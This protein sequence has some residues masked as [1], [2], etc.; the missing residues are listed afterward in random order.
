[1]LYTEHSLVPIDFYFCLVSDMCGLTVRDKLF[2]MT[3]RLSK[4]NERQIFDSLKNEGLSLP[5]KIE[6]SMLW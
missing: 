6:N 5:V 3:I 2:W 4:R 1:M